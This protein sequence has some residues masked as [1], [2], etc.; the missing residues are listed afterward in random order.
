MFHRRSDGTRI[1]SGYDAPDKYFDD[2]CPH[3]L[4]CTIV[5]WLPIFAQ[6]KY[7]NIAIE[8]L[9]FLQKL[10]RLT[11]FG[12]VIMKDHLHLISSSKNLSKEISHFKSFTAQKIL[13]LLKY[14]D[15]FITLNKMKNFKKKYRKD[16]QFQVW[17]EGSHP[18]A[19]F[20][21]EIFVQKLNYIHYN[22][23]RKGYVDNSE[24]WWYSSARNY[25]NKKSALDVTIDW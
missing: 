24:D 11:I 5:G 10:N 8:S 20:N 19:I 18:K 15:N 1:K 2:N 25:V 6:Q 16:R 21:F 9:D 13:K 3:F 22:P 4:T 14:D 7:S 23:V 12:Y 17:Q